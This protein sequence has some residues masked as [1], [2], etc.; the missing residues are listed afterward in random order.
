[1][2]VVVHGPAD[3]DYA[4]PAPSQ[5]ALLDAL[6]RNV[7]QVAAPRVPAGST[8][9]VTV[10]GLDLA[11]RFESWRE[12]QL[13]SVRIVRNVY[14]PRVELRFTLAAADGRI[15]RQGHRVLSD[16]S[17]AVLG[18]PDLPIGELRYEKRLLRDWIERE[19]PAP[20]R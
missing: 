6:A 17:G 18:A 10:L 14:S 9:T 15:G 13:A 12:P 19:F 4:R 16:P 5:S 3:V 2:E 11:G 20:G 1:M 8:L 7:R